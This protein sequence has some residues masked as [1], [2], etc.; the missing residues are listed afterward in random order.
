MLDLLNTENANERILPRALLKQGARL[1]SELQ[2]RPP[3]KMK[4]KERKKFQ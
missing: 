3:G 1:G 2:Q 4:S